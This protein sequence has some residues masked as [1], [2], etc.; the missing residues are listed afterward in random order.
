MVPVPHYSGV[1]RREQFECCKICSFNEDFLGTSLIV[2]AD[3]RLCTYPS[4][5]FWSFDYILK[6]HVHSL[7]GRTIAL[8]EATPDFSLTADG[9]NADNGGSKMVLVARSSVFVQPR[10]SDDESLE[11]DTTERHVVNRTRPACG[12]LTSTQYMCFTLFVARYE[13]A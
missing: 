1:S 10:G 11:F 5:T 9:I 2:S 7:H 12:G 8:N 3:L 4:P 13:L 6:G